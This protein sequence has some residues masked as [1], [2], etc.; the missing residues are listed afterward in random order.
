MKTRSP[1]RRL[2]TFSSRER[3]RVADKSLSENGLVR[4]DVFHGRSRLEPAPP[5]KLL[6]GVIN[7]R[8]KTFQATDEGQIVE[9]VERCDLYAIDGKRMVIPTGLV[10]AVVKRLKKSGKETVVKDHR[11]FGPTH[12]TSQQVLSEADEDDRRLL[13]AVE[14]HPL[15]QIEMSG[16]AAMLQQIHLIYRYFP[17]AS[18]L[19][20]VATSDSARYLWRELSRLAGGGVGLKKGWW[21]RRP[22]RCLITTYPS[23]ATCITDRWEIILLPYAEHATQNRFSGAMGVFVGSPCRCYSFV[24]PGQQMGRRSR[25]RLEAM[26]GQVIYDIEPGKPAVEVLWVQ[27]PQ[28][29]TSGCERRSL[30]WKRTT[31]WHNTLRN[32][33]IA[34]AAQAFAEKDVKRLRACG[35]RFQ[36][37][38]PALANSE[39]PKV[40]LLV[41]SVE[42]GQELLKRLDGWA[43]LDGAAVRRNDSSVKGEIITATRAAACGLDADVVIQAVGGAG[44]GVFRNTVIERSAAADSLPAI[45]VDFADSGDDMAAAD[46]RTRYRAY[47]R[48]GWD[49]HGF[50]RRSS[51]ERRR[52]PRFKQ[53]GV[54][55]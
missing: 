5:E 48:L 52:Q 26:S 41:E 49:Q 42:H 19:I 6:E 27:P 37:G 16:T 15:G 51:A 40:V 44:T 17:D 7:Y 38:E 14:Q 47:K 23:L 33:F 39:T 11:E 29:G 45:I 31:Y 30:E 55:R 25:I 36:D 50:P 24:R 2:K 20:P 34:E 46:V 18:I 22:P 53:K 12:N 9:Q 4:I 28:Q 13:Q 35:V 43:L 3:N 8:Q 32:Q 21:P 1:E 10:P 54:T